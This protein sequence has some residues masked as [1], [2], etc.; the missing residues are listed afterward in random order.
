MQSV[1]LP[2]PCVIGPN[3]LQ[4]PGGRRVGRLTGS[5]ASLAT[6]SSSVAS[7]AS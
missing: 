2:V 4:S 6:V 7:R 3:G 1:V 5:S